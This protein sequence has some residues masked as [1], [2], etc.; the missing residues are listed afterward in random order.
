VRIA[1]TQ[2]ERI[3]VADHVEVLRQAVEPLSV[4][5]RFGRWLV[6]TGLRIAPE[7]RPARIT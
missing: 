1:D 7:L 2:L 3:L 6:V 4:R 5:L